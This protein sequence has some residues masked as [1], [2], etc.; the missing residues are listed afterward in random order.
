MIGP[1]TVGNDVMMGPRCVLVSSAHATTSTEV[2]MNTQG[3][4]P[5]RRIVIG[6]DVWMGPVSRSFPG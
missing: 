2:P 1:L 3:F 5:D 6:D 4:A